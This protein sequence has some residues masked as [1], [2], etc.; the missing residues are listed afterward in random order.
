MGASIGLQPLKNALPVLNSERGRLD[1]QSSATPDGCVPPSIVRPLSNQHMVGEN[2]SK[3]EILAGNRLK[4]RALLQNSV[5]FH[6][7]ST[8]S[9][10]LQVLQ[11]SV[12]VIRLWSAD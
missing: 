10:L 8:L 1:F 11:L 4:T 12:W 3:T 5:Y 7:F 9:D 2:V 6:T